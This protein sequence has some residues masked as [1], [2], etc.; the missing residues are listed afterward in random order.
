VAFTDAFVSVNVRA[1]KEAPL[2]QSLVDLIPGAA[3][4]ER[5]VHDLFGVEF[6]GNPD[7]SPL[8]LPDGWPEGVYPLRK[9]WSTER[10]LSKL[11]G[12]R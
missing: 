3:I 4:Y 10:L 11:G 8:L 7:L 9:W 5:E 2:L 6:E 12:G 1:P